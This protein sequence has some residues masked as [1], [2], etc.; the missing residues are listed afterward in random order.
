MRTGDTCDQHIIYL[1]SLPVFRFL[2]EPTLGNRLLFNIQSVAQVGL[3]PTTFRLLSCS[4]QTVQPNRWEL[5]ANEFS[6]V[7]TGDT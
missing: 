1:M 3:E 2:H 7:H 5:C 6:H 4:L